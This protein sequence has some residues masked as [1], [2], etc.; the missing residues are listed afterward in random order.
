[1]T[2][3][4]RPQLRV[5]ISADLDDIK[6]GLGL[7]RGELAK[8]R[9]EAERATP[10]TGN[11]GAGVQ[12]LRGQIVALAGAYIGLNAAAAGVRSL[13]DAL[14]EADR[15]NDVSQQVN[16]GVEALSKYG[17]AAKMSGSDQEALNKGLLAF[18]KNLRENSPLL[19]QLGVDTS[20]TES[21]L[22]GVADVFAKLPESA[23]RTELATKLFGRAGAELIPLLV[24][25]REG[26]ARLGAE[27]ERLGVVVT[28]KTAAAA[29]EFNDNLDRLRAASRGVA[30]RIAEQLLPTLTVLSERLLE[31]AKDV[32]LL[33]GAFI[34]FFEKVFGGTGLGDVAKKELA[35][36]EE[37]IGS[38][39]EEINDRALAGDTKRVAVLQGELAKLEVR[40]EAARQKVKFA[41][42]LEAGA[43]PKTKSKDD[44][45]EAARAKRLAAEARLQAQLRK[46]LE[47]G[48]KTKDAAAPVDKATEGTLLAQDAL[49]RSILDLQRAYEDANLTAEQFFQ[50][51]L[52]LQEALSDLQAKDLRAELERLD[53]REKWARG[54]TDAGQRE[55]ELA[56]IQQK[57][58]DLEG[59][60]TVLGRDRA[61][62]TVQAARDQAKAEREAAKA[63]REAAEKER[64]RREQGDEDARRFR[65]GLGTEGDDPLAAE[66]RRITESYIRQLDE[67]DEFR[68][69]YSERNDEW[70]LLE[71]KARED[72]AA[73]LAQ[74]EQDR[75]RMMSSAASQ[76]FASLASIAKDFGG[77]QSKTYR[78][79]FAASKAFATAQAA[80]D[81]AQNVSK[82]M[83]Y[84]FP[85]NLPF[86][87]AAL[88]QGAQISSMLAGAQYAE[89]GKIVGPGTGTS[90]SVPILASN[91]EFMVR[92][93]V[94]SQPGM[95]QFL[96]DVNRR[97]SV[98]VSPQRFAQGGLITQDVGAA[99]AAG[100]ARLAQSSVPGA[101]GAAPRPVRNI[102]VFSED[103][104]VAALEGSAGEEV[105]VNHVRR[106][107]GAI[108]A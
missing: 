72:H 16:I 59:K 44:E 63:E 35:K 80:V 79:L 77:E 17:F 29:A 32:G 5:R 6:Q 56:A 27:A 87:A 60:L 82:A 93:A 31:N 102:I 9:A 34:T 99:M 15:L 45:D 106:N 91:G 71:I 42:E 30:L 100:E 7:L 48:G 108:D 88:A 78:T 73:R 90:D 62:L 11:F 61:D 23:E 24:E 86:I 14:D 12:A 10:N 64:V 68:R 95:L 46:L 51:R 83:S 49:K 2:T 4:A 58:L 3:G 1:M 55:R 20:S 103:E 84:G 94:V 52:V 33:Q 101:A 50:R 13:F 54:L 28:N 98:A 65:S 21:A 43:K 39:Q 19:Q 85:Q 38:L 76:G 36:I 22:Q 66:E 89:G 41:A 92:Q 107:R 53:V 75:M 70:D 81:L 67:L 69:K 104:L 57:R 26:M 74:L 37:G 97:G 40:A 18:N 105:I 47:T 25:G 8:V 96:E